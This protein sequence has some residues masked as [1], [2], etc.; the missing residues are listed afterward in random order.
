ME[1][2]CGCDFEKHRWDD[3]SG[4]G[5]GTGSRSVYNEWKINWMHF[6]AS[7]ELKLICKEKVSK[8]NVGQALCKM[9]CIC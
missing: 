9:H 4:F 8:S 7:V 6:T 3:I 5:A 2:V 1:V